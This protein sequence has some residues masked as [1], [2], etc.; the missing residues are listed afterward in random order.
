MPNARIAVDTTM[1][2][3][4]VQEEIRTELTP[5]AIREQLEILVRDHVFR[6]S[7]RS[8]QFLRDVVEETLRGAAEHIKERT[9]GVEVFGR[10]PS[11]DT[12]V[13]HVV[14][15]AAI[16]LRKRLAIYYGDPK[17]RSELRMSLVPGSYVPHFAPPSEVEPAP[18]M[19]HAL[20]AAAEESAPGIEPVPVRRVLPWVM[21]GTTVVLLACI[22]L[23]YRWLHAPGAQDLFWAPVVD[24]PG[25]VLIAVGDV[26]NGPPSPPVAGEG[27]PGDI[28]VI[29]KTSSPSVPFADMVTVARVLGI[30]DSRG[31]K[32]IIRQES[33]SSFSD[34][35][36][37][38][39]VL[40]GA[41]NNEW[42]LRLSRQMRYT[43]A[44]DPDQHL[45]YIRD[46][47]N[48]DQRT[49]AWGTDKSTQH[50][51]ESGGPPLQDYA[52]ISRIWNSE[53]GH[54]VV[55]IGGLYTYGTQA[56]GELL[57]NPQLMQAVA[58]AAPLDKAH[59]NL[60]I[61]LGTTVTDGTPGP[62][63]VLA[64]SQE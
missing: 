58:K 46:T 7:K 33:V 48:P 22:L 23:G 45:I 9:I 6:S 61:V 47:K 49:W 3:A 39:V 57:S 36:E 64:V 17:H 43:L 16:E 35:R 41:F 31:K 59:A 5:E 4:D 11:Y 60:Q 24:T 54:I 50:Q 12:N 2:P 1:L 25:T 15:T 10:E 27:R 32:V 30:L 53:T 29:H 8:V 20:P 44:L 13:D 34:L 19:P 21:A 55:V 62:P 42:S 56:A 38:P 18:E 40:I 14:R 51:G 37:G 26:P 28:P 63:R 52:L